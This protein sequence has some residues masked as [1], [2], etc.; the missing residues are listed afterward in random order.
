MIAT[1]ATASRTPRLEILERS[2]GESDF[3]KF[4]SETNSRT[5]VFQSNS[6]NAAL[7]ALN[8]QVGDGRFPL[9]VIVFSSGVPAGVAGAFCALTALKLIITADRINPVSLRG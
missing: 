5:F 4:G 7:I 6:G 2:S 1:K 3:S 8:S 9:L